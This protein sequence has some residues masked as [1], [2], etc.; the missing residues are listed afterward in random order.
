MLLYSFLSPH[1]S[2]QHPINRNWGFWKN[3]E[4][5]QCIVAQFFHRDHLRPFSAISASSHYKKRR[6][7]VSQP[8]FYSQHAHHTRTRTLI[9]SS[10]SSFLHIYIYT[11]WLNSLGKENRSLTCW[12]SPCSDPPLLDNVFNFPPTKNEICSWLVYWTRSIVFKV[13]DSLIKTLNHHVT[14]WTISSASCAEPKKFWRTNEQLLQP[15]SNS[16]QRATTSL[17]SFIYTIF[18]FAT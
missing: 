5:D 3:K 15:P 4:K 13:V 2:D 11:T 10:F 14:N 18:L 9:F 7:F 1:D 6:I 12:Q 17:M 8:I 16:I